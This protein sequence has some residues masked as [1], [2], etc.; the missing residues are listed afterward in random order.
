[1]SAKNVELRICRNCFRVFP[2][3]KA[4]KAIPAQQGRVQLEHVDSDRKDIL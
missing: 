1:M 3:G 2:L 4:A